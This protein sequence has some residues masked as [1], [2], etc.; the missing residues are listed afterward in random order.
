MTPRVNFQ[1]ENSRRNSMMVAQNAET[2]KLVEDQEK[3]INM[4]A[5]KLKEL[6]KERDQERFLLFPLPPL[7]P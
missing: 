5:T 4:Q 2:L 7:T 3:Q 6:S 1:G